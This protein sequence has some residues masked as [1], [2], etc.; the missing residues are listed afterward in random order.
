MFGDTEYSHLIG[1]EIEIRT[2]LSYIYY[3]IKCPVNSIQIKRLHYGYFM[4][5]VSVFIP[6]DERRRFYVVHKFKKKKNLIKKF[7]LYPV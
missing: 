5:M 7:K 3:S 6:D 2:L 4:I 1:Q